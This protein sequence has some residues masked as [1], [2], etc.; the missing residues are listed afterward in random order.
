MSVSPIFYL[1]RS[2]ISVLGKVLKFP[3]LPG[4]NPCHNTALIIVINYKSWNILE[5][6][7]INNSAS[8]ILTK[9]D[10]NQI[11]SSSQLCWVNSFDSTSDNWKKREKTEKREKKLKK[12][13]TN[14]ESF[15][16]A[17]TLVK[18]FYLWQVV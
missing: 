12:R 4:P 10:S 18:I 9:N 15:H 17:T 8:I 14:V 7:T 16:F 13:I 2:S 5:K 11:N 1:H 3:F 6:L